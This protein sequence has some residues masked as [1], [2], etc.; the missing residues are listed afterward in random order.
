M[1]A[2]D[3]IRGVDTDEA[4]G[5]AVT[6][7]P[8]HNR[9]DTRCK[10][11]AERMFCIHLDEGGV[12]GMRGFVE[13]KEWRM[14][15]RLRRNTARNA[16]ARIQVLKPFRSSTARSVLSTTTHPWRAMVRTCQVW[17]ADRISLLRL[18]GNAYASRFFMQPR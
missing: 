15:G 8:R 5:E 9:L 12:R 3:P 6:G 18:V 13:G 14:D 17:T 4:I 7:C 11:S 2:T 16:A 1:R 10:L